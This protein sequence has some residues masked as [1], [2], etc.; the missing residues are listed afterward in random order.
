MGRHVKLRC[1]RSLASFR[2]TSDIVIL[3]RDQKLTCPSYDQNQTQPG[4][5]GCECN[6]LFFVMRRNFLTAFAVFPARPLQS[7][8]TLQGR[9]HE[10]DQQ[11]RE[12]SRFLYLLL[13]AAPLRL[14]YT[15][16]KL[17]VHGNAAA[18]ANNI[19]AHETLFRFGIVGDLFT[20]TMVIFVALA[21]YRLFKAVDQNQA[22]LMVIL[23]AS[24]HPRSTSS[25]R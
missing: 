4:C 15:P 9:E 7:P 13:L 24:C 25:M 10:L 19:T 1:G 14:I 6:R 20:G 3:I 17:F 11:S 12:S 16:S 5:R 8:L 22:V 21:L 2:R 23:G 18:T